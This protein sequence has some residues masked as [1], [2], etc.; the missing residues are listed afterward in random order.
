MTPI[1]HFVPGDWA[2]GRGEEVLSRLRW[3]IPPSVIRAYV[4]AYSRP[5]DRVLVPF[6]QDAAEVREV[7]HLGRHA[8]AL[9]YDPVL[10]LVV[11]AAL[12]PVSAKDLDAAVARL[13][14]SRKQ[15]IPLRK[16]LDALYATTCPACLRP[17]VADYFIWEQGKP[18]A[19]QVHCPACDFDGQTGVEPADLE[20]LADIP[21]RGMHFYY[22][23]DRVAPQPA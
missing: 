16:H 23:L 22:V 18:A 5:G 14:D 21:A 15:G 9:H 8:L 6:C 1:E 2:E 20:R 19:K 4:E 11:Q 3:P 7:L 17:A 10:L 12:E 13:G